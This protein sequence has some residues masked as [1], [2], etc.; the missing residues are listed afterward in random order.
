MKKNFLFTALIIMG[1]IPVLN[2]QNT[3]WIS[4]PQVGWNWQRGTISEASLSVHPKGLYLEYGLYLTF[5]VASNNYNAATQLEIA[6]D[7]QLPKGAIVLDSWLWVGDDIVQ[8]KLIDRWSASDI[9]EGIV[10]RRRDPS[11]LFKNSNTQYQLRVYPLKNYETRKVKITYLMP[12]DWNRGKIE[13]TLPVNIL[14]TSSQPPD[15]WLFLWE[16]KGFENPVLQ[17]TDIIFESNSDSAFG[18]FRRA[19]VPYDKLTATTG[20][21]LDA[22]LRNGIY[23]SVFEDQNTSYYQMALSPGSFISQVENQRILVL[24]DYEAGNSFMSKADLIATLKQRMLASYSPSDS[25]NLMYSKLRVE[26]AFDTWK[27]VTSANLNAAFDPLLTESMYSNLPGLCSTALDFLK[28]TGGQ[29]SIFLVSNSDNFG[30]YEQANALIKDL[31]KMQ[32]PLPPFYI[33]DLQDQMLNYYYIGS[34]YYYGQEYLYVNLSKASSGYFKSVREVPSVPALLTDVIGSIEG[35][36]TAFDLYTAPADGFCYGRFGTNIIEGIPVNQTVTQVGKFYGQTPFNIYLTGLYQTQPF[37]QLLQ[38]ESNQIQQADTMLAKMWHG[39]YIAELEKGGNNN[40]IVQEILFESLNN[41]VLSIHSAFLCLEPSDSVSVCQTC[42][43]ESRLV[44]IDSEIRMDSAGFVKLYPNPF[45]DKVTMEISMDQ[46][47]E[48]N[49]LVIRIFNFTGQLVFE[50]AEEVVPGRLVTTEWSGTGV[51]GEE[52]PAGQ[53]VVMI[54]A[55]PRN[56]SKK[57]MKME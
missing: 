57:L 53:Y 16:D 20:L 39:R 45:R 19:F 41:R 11:V 10:N 50:K 38:I 32:D 28:T 1:L 51:N 17:N 4:D 24:I 40:M 46:L 7:F 55:G 14:Q 30:N 34:R 2:A 8:G 27:P 35:M 44:G 47:P 21:S 3:L 15:L 12:V 56:W 9:Y 22:P 13:S 42:N 29:G 37:S 25:F 48:V 31:K 6:L 18:Q 52:C 54:Q 49:Q 36:I 26:Q 33:A 43:D 23:L 5:S